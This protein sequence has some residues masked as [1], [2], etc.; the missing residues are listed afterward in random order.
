MAQNM[1]VRQNPKRLVNGEIFDGGKNTVLL[2]TQFPWFIYS[3]VQFPDC[4]AGN[5]SRSQE[6]L[7]GSVVCYIRSGGAARSRSGAGGTEEDIIGLVPT[8]N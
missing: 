7:S 5:M 8:F 1:F 4:M 2:L 3:T 6:T